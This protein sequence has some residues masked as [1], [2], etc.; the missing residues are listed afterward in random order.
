M[1]AYYFAK[2]I[3]EENKNVFESRQEV[4]EF[5]NIYLNYIKVDV[6]RYKKTHISG[7]GT[8]LPHYQYTV[9]KK[10]KKKRTLK[11]NRKADRNRFKEGIGSW[12]NRFMDQE[13]L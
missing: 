12:R 9:F 7:I 2:Q 8:F 13:I 6:N 11:L 4:E 10:K 1:N 3:Y 5:L